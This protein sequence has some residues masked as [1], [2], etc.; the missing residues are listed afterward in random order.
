MSRESGPISFII[1]LILS[2]II[3]ASY[4]LLKPVNE[5]VVIKN[6][7][8]EKE[9]IV[10]LEPEPVEV[11]FEEPTDEVAIT[12]DEP[13]PEVYLQELNSNFD[14]TKPSNLTEEDLIRALGGIRNGLE[15]TIPAI[16]EAE[17]TYGIN[18]L[19]LTALLGYES[20]WGKYETGTNNIAGW[21]GNEG[22]WS[23]FDSRYECVMTISDGLINDFAVNNGSDIYSVASRYCPDY[24]YLET[25][26]LIMSELESNL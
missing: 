6:T 19:Y 22:Y 1:C 24:Q 2:F 12:I 17:K 3:T 26:L 11:I 9:V 15:S 10:Y 23:D 25:L 14:I 7:I 20:G 4:V 21:K 16:V 18:S 8:I 5:R 13:E